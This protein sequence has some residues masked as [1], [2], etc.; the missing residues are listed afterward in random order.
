MGKEQFKRDLFKR[1][2]RESMESKA[3]EVLEKINRMGT[4]KPDEFDYVQEGGMCNECGLGEMVEGMCNECGYGKMSME[5]EKEMSKGQKY[6]AKQAEPEDEIDGE[7]FKKLRQKRKSK[8]NELEDPDFFKD[9]DKFGAKIYGNKGKSH[10]NDE[11]M[12]MN[13]DLSP[14]YG[15]DGD[16]MGMSKPMGDMEVYEDEDI[17]ENVMYELET[18]REIDEWE[19]EEGNE[20]T[21]AL[22]K[23]KER[24]D[25]DFM[26]DGKKYKVREGMEKKGTESSFR[27]WCDRYDLTNEEGEVTKSCIDKAMKS[28]DTKVIKMATSAA[29]I[30]GFLGSNKGIKKKKTVKESA[31]FTEREIISIIEKIVNEEKDNIKK[32]T[33][34]GLDTYN[35]MHKES[36]NENDDY[37]KSLTKK[38]NEF[39]GKGS[40]IKYEMNPEE[41]PMGN[42]DMDKKAFELSDEGEDFNYEIGGLQIPVPDGV[43]FNEEWIEDNY[44]GSSRT[45]NAPGGNALKSKSN[46]RHHEF[47]ERKTLNKL[48]NQSYKRVSSPVFNEKPGTEKGKGMTIKL[49]SIGEK[50]TE[51]INEEFNKIKNLISYDRKTQ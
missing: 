19:M 41:F 8:M 6:I 12:E 18:T 11:D 28:N 32:E 39:Q 29:N 27:K 15:S 48:K 26:V 43:D 20:F 34:K 50:K 7:D 3:E 13:D 35:K 51:K 33:H 47:A 23:A 9:A 38:M 17:D 49:E 14:S 36:G 40:K 25:D 24:G 42:G 21:G 30:G 46:K 37:I 1:L 4:N 10:Y 22:T 16:F 5:E 2:L 44:L 45:G 31:L